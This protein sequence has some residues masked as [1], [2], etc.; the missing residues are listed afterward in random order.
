VLETLGGGG[1]G[2]GSGILLLVLLLLLLLLLLLAALPADCV[3]CWAWVLGLHGCWACARAGLYHGDT[4][5][6]ERILGDTMNAAC[7]LYF[8]LVSPFAV[9]CAGKASATFQVGIEA[10][11][12]H[13]QNE[14]V[15]W[16]S[17]SA[18]IIGRKTLSS[19][20]RIPALGLCLL[21][22]HVACLRAG[23]NRTYQVGNESRAH[24][25]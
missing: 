10:C 22:L 7:L 6:H 20:E 17:Q 4:L 25:D 21:S 14:S 5:I 19:G 15:K 12:H 16:T 24:E 1:Q 8:H 2:V 11:A 18:R 23:W 9:A 13:G 3:G